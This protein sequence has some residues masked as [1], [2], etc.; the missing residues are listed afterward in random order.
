MRG[1]VPA[2]PRAP[3][4]WCAVLQTRPRPLPACIL[5]AEAS[6]PFRP[7]PHLHPALP[8]CDF[9]PPPEPSPLPGL[10][11]PVC[12]LGFPLLSAP[13]APLRA[14]VSCHLCLRA[15]SLRSLSSLSLCTSS[16]GFCP[17][18]ACAFLGSGLLSP[19]CAP[20]ICGPCPCLPAPL[21]WV[22]SLSLA[23]PLLA[24]VFVVI[25]LPVHP[26]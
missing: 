2:P 18:S 8:G 17:F 24:G 4:G 11:I 5:R 7:P 26:G 14:P 3:R 25:S 21:L 13:S 12:T 9:A 10:S 23:A 6:G 22:P 20:P 15:S 16:R 19:L 1:L